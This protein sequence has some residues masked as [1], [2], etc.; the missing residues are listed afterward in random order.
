M[1]TV[2]AYS[3]NV[4]GQAALGLCLPF[5]FLMQYVVLFCYSSFSFFMGVCDK[6]AENGDTKKI[7]QMNLLMTGIVALLYG[8]V[9]FACTFLA[10]DAMNALVNHMPEFLTHGLTVAGGILP[11]IGF[12]MLLNVMMKPKYI[13]YFIA[14]FLA[15]CFIDMKNLLPV[16]L[17]GT[18][19]ALFD[20]YNA[21]Q[22]QEEIK[23]AVKNLKVD[24]GDDHV[25][26]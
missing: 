4:D 6:A 15:V 23:E 25:G 2:I 12:G 16:A 17:M 1:C 9:V 20:F 26:I 8:V 18:A 19:F 7:A 14:G 21:K 3:T 13:P 11:A 22:R 5:S 24:G 10:Q